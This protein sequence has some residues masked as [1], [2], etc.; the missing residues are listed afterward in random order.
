MPPKKK[1]PAKKS[2]SSGGLKVSNGKRSTIRTKNK[3]KGT[4]TTSTKKDDGAKDDTAVGFPQFSRFPVEIQ[5]EIFTQALRKPSI[6]YIV[7]KRAVVPGYTNDD[8][9]WIDSTW[10]LVFYPRAKSR[11]PSG[12]R[13]NKKIAA[14]NR[15]AQQ[16]V[17]LAMKKPGEL[18]FAKKWNPID[19]NNDLV[20]FDFIPGATKNE[21]SNFRYFHVDNQFLAPYFDPAA[22][23]PEGK[24]KIVRDNTI[25][26]SNPSGLADIKRVG[27][28]YKQ[29]GDRACSNR[30]TVFQCCIHVE[31]SIRPH[32]D[33]IMCPDEVAGFI[34]SVPSIEEL[35]FLVQPQKNKKEEEERLQ[36]YK[37]W[38]FTSE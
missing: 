20:V 11:D 35:Y 23:Y 33:W 3:G 28:I 12:S 24:S 10:H 32:S 26:S 30:N 7:V 5:Q 18:P 17:E 15:V 16:A 21:E 22:S 25:V 29:N 14:V 38:F 31:G 19:V 8:G 37:K 4:A 1:A 34:D 13:M 2:A 6:H 27:L 36:L 9:N